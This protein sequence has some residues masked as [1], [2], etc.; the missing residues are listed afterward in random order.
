[1]EDRSPLDTDPRITLSIGTKQ[2]GRDAGLFELTRGL[3]FDHHRGLLFVSDTY[4]GRVQVLCS[5]DGSFVSEYSAHPYGIVLDFKHNRVL[6]ANPDHRC[7]AVHSLQ[8][9]SLI[10]HIA[11]Q[12][13]DLGYSGPALELD[14]PKGLAID[15]RRGRLIVAERL[16]LHVLSLKDYSSLFVIGSYGGGPGAFSNPTAVALDHDRD[17][18]IVA[19]RDNN[20]VQVLSAVDGSFLFEFGSYGPE[21][22][23]FRHP[24]S[25]C[26]DN[27]GRIIVVDTSNHRLQAFT[28]E[29]HHI[30]SFECGSS[31]NDT[32]RGIAFDEHRGLIAFSAGNRVHVIGANQWLA[33]TFTW[34]PDRHRYAPSWTKQAIEVILMVRSVARESV[35]SII[36]NEL[37]FL[38]FTELAASPH[39]C[40]IQQEDHQQE[41]PH[42]PSSSSSSSSSKQ[43][44]KCLIM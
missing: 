12:C 25:M 28:P 1:M 15:R 23:D 11:R 8:D 3:A 18:I 6:V 21:P 24:E 19:D 37:L 14:R 9:Y 34:R 16:Q 32:P 17:R 29:G 27:Q 35:I 20:R 13:Y 39:S 2:A 38:I 26:I 5:D 30:S 10:E 33:D 36:P 4:N 44:R 22:G 31:V 40:A 42:S 41:E 43:K 7:V